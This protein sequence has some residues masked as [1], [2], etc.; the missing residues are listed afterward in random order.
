MALVGAW[1]AHGART[2]VE[3]AL[4]ERLEASV[5]SL[6]QTIGY[7][8]IEQRSVLYELASDSR[9]REAAAH[10]VPVVISSDDPMW[11]PLDAVLVGATVHGRDGSPAA[12][13]VLRGAEDR[14]DPLAATVPVSLPIHEDLLGE[15]IGTLD[16]DVRVSELLPP[17]FWLA[18][19]GGGMVALFDADDEPLLPSPL[20]LDLLRSPQFSWNGEQWIAAQQRLYEPPLRIAAAVSLGPVAGPLA[21]A[22]QRGLAALILVSVLALVAATVVS[23]RLTRSLEALA[24]VSE[25]VSRGQLDTSLEEKGSVE[26]RR[27][28]RAFNGMTRSLRELLR[29]LARQRSAAAVGEFATSLAHEVRNPLTAVRLDLEDVRDQL[30]DPSTTALLDH[31]LAQVD[32]L[33][34][35]VRG[36]LR[37]AASGA[38]DLEPI[39]LNAPVRA[40][41]HAAQPAAVERGVTIQ[42]ALRDDP[43][44]VRGNAAAIEQLVL[45]LLLNGV[46]A[47]GDGGHVSVS[48]EGADG[49]AVVAVMDDGPGISPVDLARVEEPFFTTKPEGTGLGLALVRRIADAHGGELRLE[50]GSAGTRATFELPVT[51]GK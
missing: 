19:I 9:V 25:T 8:W 29:A 15:R 23:T 27:V 47:V 4:R 31:A 50:S 33:D 35:T 2:S 12:H 11:R 30:A 37:L 48:T 5:T 45:N 3:V 28:S 18:G 10:G 39:D 20:D 14:H 13:V 1:L 36:T 43:I 51:A 38:L 44:P 26:V 34:A 40:A 49:T 17:G 24:S 16:L 32:R 22:T 46:E 41:L 7:R 42:D 6:G 21:G